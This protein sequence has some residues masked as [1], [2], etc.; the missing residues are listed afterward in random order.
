LAA[1]AA[2]LKHGDLVAAASGG[3]AAQWR[4]LARLSAGDATVPA[5]ARA[6]GYSRQAI[7]RL[8]DNLVREDPARY[9]AFDPGKRAQPGDLTNKGR[10]A[11]AAMED[12]FNR[13]ARRM[14]AKVSFDELE[15]ASAELE[16]IATV[17]VDDVRAEAKRR[18]RG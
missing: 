2:V 14:S 16:K 3:T 9:S 4:T 6:T 17:L 10:K 13:W 18:R 5:I 1:N 8:V 15:R 11:L 7:Q 12:D